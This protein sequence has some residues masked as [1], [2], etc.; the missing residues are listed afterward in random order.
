MDIS[1]IGP[2]SPQQI[3]WRRLTAKEIIK[4]ETQGVDVPSQYLQWAKEFIASVYSDDTTTYEM[5]VSGTTPPESAESP[6][7]STEEPPTGISAAEEDTESE[8]EEDTVEED[9]SATMPKNTAQIE[10][11]ELNQNGVSLRSQARIFRKESRRR[12]W[13]TFIQRIGVSALQKQSNTELLKLQH[14][15]T[16][17]LSRAESAQNEFKQQVDEINNGTSDSMT[18]AK[19]NMLQDRLQQYGN[20]GVAHV[21]SSEADF[22]EYQANLD[23]RADIVAEAADF[24]VETVDIGNELL[25]SSRLSFI[26]LI[27]GTSAIK[28]GNRTSSLAGRVAGAIEQATGINI[29]NFNFADS[30]RT[31][32][33]DKT[34]V[35]SESASLTS[36]HSKEDNIE[37]ENENDPANQDKIGTVEDANALDPANDSSANIDRILQYKIRQGMNADNTQT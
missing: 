1:R 19:M 12:F 16:S 20:S 18:F 7:A 3:D 21:S 31:E 25:S 9:E 36:R 33:E 26:N 14:Y 8:N 37:A 27:I 22:N 2:I 5:A 17:L 23:G 30:Y 11:E 24:G 13:Q 6:V 15:M 4:Y 32:I 34:G 28:S 35:Q 10:R 29:S